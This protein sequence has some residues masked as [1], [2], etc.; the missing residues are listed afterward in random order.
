MEK[1]YEGASEPFVMSDAYARRS[2]LNLG[3]WWIWYGGSEAV[4]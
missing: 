3:S 2:G 4:E 1:R